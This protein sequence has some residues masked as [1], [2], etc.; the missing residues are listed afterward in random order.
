MNKEIKMVFEDSD[1]L[2]INK[3]AGLLVHKKHPADTETTLVDWLIKKYPEIKNVG[4]DLEVRPGIVHRLDRETSGLMIVAK[5]Q[6]SFSYFKKLFQDRKINKSYL[7]LVRGHLKNKEGVVDAPMAKIGTRQT[8][9][10]HGKKD[11]EEKSAITEYKVIK[12]FTEFSLL[13]ARPLTG[14]TNQ[15][16]VHLKSIGHPIVCDKIYAGR[17]AVCPPELGR[18]FL[19]AHKLRF[20]SPSGESLSLEA[21]PA[22]ELASFLEQLQKDNK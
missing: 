4:D 8:T 21:D 17:R 20:V 19:H 10:I 18:L 6:S 14:R 11:L 5:N 1:F 15:I 16:R 9:R 22:P 13:E 7:A 3:P 2:V 12:E